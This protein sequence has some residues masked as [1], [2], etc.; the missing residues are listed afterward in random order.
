MPSLDPSIRSTNDRRKAHPKKSKF[1]LTDQIL[2]MYTGQKHYKDDELFFQ[3]SRSISIHQTIT[4]MKIDP[5]VDMS[6][7]GAKHLADISPSSANHMLC[8]YPGLEELSDKVSMETLSSSQQ[9]WLLKELRA[10]R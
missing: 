3:L 10:S 9:S 4:S 7:I 2:R 5:P 8:F 6:G 1:K